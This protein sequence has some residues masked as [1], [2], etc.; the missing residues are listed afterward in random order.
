MEANG[1]TSTIEP[2]A[3]AAEGRPAPF[4]RDGRRRPRP[5]PR[6]ATVRPPRPAGR[7]GSG[8]PGSS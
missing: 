2:E 6:A 7:R 5:R 3:I 1:P 8:A 4:G